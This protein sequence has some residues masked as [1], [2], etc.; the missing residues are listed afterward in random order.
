MPLYR[1]TNAELDVLIA[2]CEARGEV[3]VGV[4]TDESRMDGFIITTSV[5]VNDTGRPWVPSKLTTTLGETESRT[6]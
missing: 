2:V 5:P 1:T 3:I 6:A 4:T